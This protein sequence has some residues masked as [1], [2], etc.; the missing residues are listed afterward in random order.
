MRL[1][2]LHMSALL[3]LCLGLAACSDDTVKDG[4]SP[5]CQSYE[6]LNPITGTCMPRAEGGGS[7]GGG[8]TGG[9]TDGGGTT[10]GDGGTTG[11][12]GTSGGGPPPPPPPAGNCESGARQCA[13]DG[14]SDVCIQGQWERTVCR[15]GEGCQNGFCTPTGCVP[16]SVR[17]N[18]DTTYES[19]GQDGQY[20]PA[21]TC[22]ADQVCS[23]GQCILAACAGS[24]SEKSN[25]GCDY[26]SIRHHIVAPLNG[27]FAHSVVVSNPGDRPATLR[28][29]SPMTGDLP[30]PQ[31]IVQPLSSVVVEFP[32]THRVET[33]GISNLVYRI[34]TDRPVIAT[35]F[36][37]LN[38]PGRLRE[39]S[40]ASIMLP[41]N[42]L[43][44]EYVTLGWR[45]GPGQ[46]YVDIVATA[47]G[48]TFV[49]VQSP[50][51]LNGGSAGSVNAG[52]TTTYRMS[53]DQVLHLADGVGFLGSAEQRDMSGIIVTSTQPVA[54]YTGAAIVNIP[55]GP[56]D[57]LQAGDHIENQMFPVQF[58]G[59]RY[60][61]SP[62]K[63]RTS[64]D[65][66]IFRVAAA[67]DGTEITLDPAINGLSTFT[68][69]RGQWREFRT[70]SAFVLTATKPVQLGQYMI[71]GEIDSVNE[72]GDPAFAL[73][74]AVE[75]YRDEYVFLVPA[76]YRR[77]FVTVSAPAAA[78]ITL[79]GQVVP[80]NEFVPVGNG[81][82]KVAILTIAAGVH[83]ASSTEPFGL[84]IHGYDFYI[85][86]AFPGGLKLE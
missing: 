50:I 62:F 28:V 2:R 77:N 63:S 86:Y 7:T 58:W 18:S 76:G 71:G 72:D 84:L 23:R 19:C 83:T 16:G 15:A 31:N 20:G 26:V 64:G 53:Q 8:A 51:K 52:G 47:P 10:I 74:A 43:G 33:P 24:L 12:G 36:A 14:A 30:L 27:Q 17:C 25:Q 82:W 11:G 85:S 35:Q 55:D 3:G 21:Q 38:N 13:G 61:G 6:V 1:S 56:D 54:V 70:P 73:P 39:S 69:N 48:E 40:D 44:S 42:S 46:A 34:T 45:S 32:T 5:T 9:G 67:Q 41:T 75:H 59:T 37:P 65:F 81:T 22:E 57:G 4:S 60:V 29:S 80:A 79:D 66:M 78:Q 68:L 49:T